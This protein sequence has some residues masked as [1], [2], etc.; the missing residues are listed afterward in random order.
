MSRQIYPHIDPYSTGRLRVS[1]VHEIYYEECGNPDG[2]P[3]L[4]LHGGPGG[5]AT[6]S[7]RRY[8]D[9]RA[10][11]IVLFDQ[12]G[13]GRSTPHASLEENT[14]WRLLEDIEALRQHLDIDSWLVFGGSWG[15]TLALTYA[16]NHPSQVSELVLRGIFLLRKQEIDWFYQNGASWFHP[17]AWEDFLAPIPEE[18]RGDLLPAYYTRLTGDDPAERLK[19]AKA[20]SVWEG[21]AVTLLPSPDRKNAFASDN[22]ALAFARIET[23]YFVNRGFFPSDNYLLDNIEK[24]R[25]IPGTIVHGRYDVVTPL[26]S[27]W[28]LKKAW[29][30]SRLVIAPQSGHAASEPEI[31]DA[32]I[33]TTDQYRP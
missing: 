18:E 10:Y 23:H 12:R 7:M 19:A 6:P 26:R 4:V 33:Q 29:P 11:R 21:G 25:Q 16:V 22:F 2:K 17:D 1:D 13:C 9:P 30:E 14:T 32:L 24:I 3:A 31:V 28:D 15:S 27:A 20:W 8:F 5:G